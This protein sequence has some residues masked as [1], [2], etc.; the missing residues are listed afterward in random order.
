MGSRNIIWRIFY[1]SLMPFLIIKGTLAKKNRDHDAY[2]LND[3]VYDYARNVVKLPRIGTFYDISLQSNYSG[4][5]ISYIQIR[6]ANL[7]TRGINSS[8]VQIPRRTRIIPFVKRLDIVFQD[9]GSLSSYY[10]NVPHHRF[11]TPIIGFTIYDADNDSSS[12]SSAVLPNLS[13][14][15]NSTILIQ[16][17]D[18][19]VKKV[20]NATLRCVTFGANGTMEFNNVTEPNRCHVSGQGYFSIIVPRSN[21]SSKERRK[22]LAIGLGVG[23]GGFLLLLIVFLRCKYA[24]KKKLKLMQRQSE[25]SE[26]LDTVWVGWSKMPSAGWVR[27]VAVPEND[28]A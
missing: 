26:N 15:E 16:F 17:P 6:T 1:V 25:K 22:R 27:T 8:A 3:F 14:E 5:K 7:W 2:S 9:L 28:Y 13:L 20:D 24:R 18:I 21:S 4:I 10:Y 23:I 19:S 12:N 11:V